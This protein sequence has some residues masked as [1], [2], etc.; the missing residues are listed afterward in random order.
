MTVEQTF[1]ITIWGKETYRTDMKGEGNL[2]TLTLKLVRDKVI[3]KS[4]HPV[5]TYDISLSDLV[6]ATRLLEEHSK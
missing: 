3:V 2:V 1:S 5:D 4:D 6:E